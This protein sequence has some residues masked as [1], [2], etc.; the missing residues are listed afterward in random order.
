MR[1]QIIKIEMSIHNYIFVRALRL[2]YP[3][4]NI[5]AKSMYKQQYFYPYFAYKYQNQA[6]FGLTQKPGL[7]SS[8][9]TKWTSMM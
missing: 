4:D 6:S 7:P 5:S 8:H 2:F 9:K 3:S 1:C